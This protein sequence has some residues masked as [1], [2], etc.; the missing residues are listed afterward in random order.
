MCCSGFCSL[1]QLHAGA[2]WGCWYD[3]WCVCKVGLL[4]GARAGTQLSAVNSSRLHE[5]CGFRAYALYL[6]GVDEHAQIWPILV[7]SIGPSAPLDITLV[8]FCCCC[9]ALCP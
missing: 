3:W 8:L 6:C 1:S 2:C 7:H 4:M 5:A 9:R